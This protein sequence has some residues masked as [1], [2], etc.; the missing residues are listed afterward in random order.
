MRIRQ[1]Q[2]NIDAMKG[3][4][5]QILQDLK[6]TQCGPEGSVAICGK[7]TILY[8]IPREFK[9]Q[10]TQFQIISIM[11]QNRTKAP[12]GGRIVIQH[13][14]KTNELRTCLTEF[15]SNLK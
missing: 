11:E 1:V 9:E 5:D 3:K 14:S 7:S 2:F 12:G 8:S 6:S 4:V 15:L 13:N 10:P